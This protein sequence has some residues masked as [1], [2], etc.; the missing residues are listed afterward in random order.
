MNKTRS[1]GKDEFFGNLIFVDCPHCGAKLTAVGVYYLRDIISD[2]RTVA[3][4]VCPVCKGF[5]DKDWLVRNGL[6]GAD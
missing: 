5:L 3:G 6:L 2:S 1:I 4:Y